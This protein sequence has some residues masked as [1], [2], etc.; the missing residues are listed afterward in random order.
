MDKQKALECTQ[1]N[2][3]VAYNYSEL[4]HL[5]TS[6]SLCL[7]W[8]YL[9]VWLG[10]LLLQALFGL[11]FSWLPLSKW[12]SELL[13]KQFMHNSMILTR[14]IDLFHAMLISSFLPTL[15]LYVF[16]ADTDSNTTN[17]AAPKS[18]SNNDWVGRPMADTIV[19]FDVDGTLSPSRR[20][21]EWWR[22]RW[23]R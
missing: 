21:L 1:A 20:V 14:E 2:R 16:A 11:P 15:L 17:S 4:M 22:W 10:H 8:L 5:V 12:R 19:L 13:T 3:S 9:R 18:N 23:C 6:E 7:Y